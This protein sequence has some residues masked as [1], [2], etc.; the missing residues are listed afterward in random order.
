[1]LKY[2]KYNHIVKLPDGNAFVLA[3]FR[4]G[5]VVRLTPLSKAMFDQATE[6]PETAKPI[7]EFLRGGFLVGYD[8]MRHMRTQALQASGAG[9]GLGITVCPTLACNFACPYCFESARPG[10]MSEETQDA[11]VKFVEE[12]M[13]LFR[14]KHFEVTWFGGEP[15]LFPCIIESLSERFIDICQKQG[16]DYSAG[17]ITNGWFLT[18][19]NARLLERVKVKMMQITLDGPTPE[20]NDRTRREKSGGSSF[21]RIME[22]LSH[23]HPYAKEEG[24]EEENLPRI[25]IR[26]NVHKGNAP[27]F[28]ELKEK[29]A[30]IAKE[31]GVNISAYPSIMDACGE[32]PRAVKDDALSME[33]FADI[34]D[35]D[36]MSH[37]EGISAY[38]RVF[39]MAHRLHAYAI[40]ERGYLYKCW[41]DVG[42]SDMAFGNVK[43]FSLIR[44][45]DAR[46]NMEDR[47]FETLFPED[48][49]EC[50]ECKVFPLCVGGCPHKRITTGRNCPPE[51]MNPD[52]YV[53]ARWREKMK[54]NE[55]DTQA[56]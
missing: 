48:D 40:D 30:A 19:K 51:K 23:L 14:L 16:A 24:A 46:I 45:P 28:G 25:H 32:K 56:K 34:L 8:E 11:L 41:E 38:R 1:M 47:Y 13:R 37:R 54:K 43:S 18:E 50:M 52:G 26:C 27:L 17:I 9:D 4:T 44:E 10:R 20:A 35:S 31:T 12:E 6:L 15:L 53:L 21:A 42:R 2:S 5:A 7:R 3:N 22:N 29:I 36:A 39:C 33:Q 49:K 55:K